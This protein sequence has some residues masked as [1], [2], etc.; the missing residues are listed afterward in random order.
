L[1][2]FFFYLIL[3][4]MPCSINFLHNE[5]LI[6]KRSSAAEAGNRLG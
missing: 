6:L 2:F 3:L 1:I 5:Y 4:I